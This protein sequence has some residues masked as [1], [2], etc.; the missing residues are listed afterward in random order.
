MTALLAYGL[1][2]EWKEEPRSWYRA[3]DML[4]IEDGKRTLLRLKYAGIFLTVIALSTACSKSDSLRRE[5]QREW[6]FKSKENH[7]AT[8]ASEKL[9]ADEFANQPDLQS[10]IL[11]MP[12]DEVVA[13]LGYVTYKA[14]S[15]FKLERN[16]QVQKVFEETI[17]EQGQAGAYRVIQTDKAGHLLREHIYTD[18]NH[19]VRNG[20][21]ALRMVGF[22]H[23]DPESTKKE[24][25]SVLSTFIQC[26]GEQLN[27]K[28]T[29]SRR[30]FKRKTNAY[31]ISVGKS[32]AAH[33]VE[34]LPF[35]IRP[36]KASGIIHI[37]TETGVPLAA[38]GLKAKLMTIYNSGSSE[39]V[40]LGSL[41]LEVD[42]EIQ[43]HGGRRIEARDPI[44]PIQRR[45][46]DLDPLA[47]L[48]KKTHK[49]TIIGGK[50]N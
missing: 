8:L 5:S 49:S 4:C 34:D 10:R 41:A 6:G 33:N 29:R 15:T 31:R 2:G 12:F 19:Y 13:R 46:V 42:Y 37:D 45:P 35:Q 21:G 22:G 3:L 39:G 48:K 23:K 18:G 43:T 20:P 32:A 47:F 40:E 1:S 44:D 16:E 14:R 9:D 25:F 24:A 38:E 17:I 36:T 50:N 27:L 30:R 26:L 28:P 11:N 7:W